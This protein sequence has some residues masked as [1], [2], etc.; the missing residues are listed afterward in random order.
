MILTISSVTVI[1]WN[2]NSSSLKSAYIP[3]YAIRIR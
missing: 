1:T 2:A 3:N